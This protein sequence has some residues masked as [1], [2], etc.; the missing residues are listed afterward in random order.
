MKYWNET[1]PAFHFASL[2]IIWDLFEAFLII[3]DTSQHI[4][5]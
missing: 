3:V 2:D 1:I 5:E 4:Y